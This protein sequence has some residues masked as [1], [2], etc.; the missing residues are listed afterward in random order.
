MGNEGVT[1]GRRPTE[2]QC[3]SVEWFTPPAILEPVRALRL[4]VEGISG[5][6]IDPCTTPLNPTS[7]DNWFTEDDDGL[8]KGWSMSDY[9]REY[10]FIFA[11]PPYGRALYAWIAKAVAEAELGCRIVLL[12]AASSRW[13]QLGWQRLNSPH[14]TAICTPLG[15]VKFLDEHGQLRDQNPYPSML[16][17]YN[18]PIDAIE[19]CF[20]HLGAVWP[21][22]GGDG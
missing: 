16:F 9:P 14:L 8:S 15:R 7:A 4:K 10:P 1:M 22:G 17:F 6:G 13:D 3:R 18:L 5:I 11:N 21:V 19:A 20:G 12:L 2:K